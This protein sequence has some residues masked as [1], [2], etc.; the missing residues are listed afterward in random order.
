MNFKDKRTRIT[1]AC[2]SAAVVV[3]G[4]TVGASFA[5]ATG[6]LTLTTGNAITTLDLGQYGF[7]SQQTIAAG[8]VLS[9]QDDF[10]LTFGANTTGTLAKTAT[11]AQVA[12]ALN[13]LASVTTAG[14]VSVVQGTAGDLT[15]AGTFIVRFLQP[16]V[17]AAITGTVN[18]HAGTGTGAVAVNSTTAGNNTGNAGG[19]TAPA[20][21]ANATFGTKVNTTVVG[22]LTLTLDSYTAPSGATLTG[23]PYLEYA[24]QASGPPRGRRVPTRGRRSPPPPRALP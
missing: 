10:T 14:G 5:S 16:G 18:H 12:T 15:G 7:G 20:A 1:A 8:T 9:D 22:A 11:A 19:G 2:A 23:T 6:A 4:V 13:G 21:I 3:G 17:R 24:Q